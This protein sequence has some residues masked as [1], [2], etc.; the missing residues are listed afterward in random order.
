[1]FSRRTSSPSVNCLF[2]INNRKTNSLVNTCKCKHVNEPVNTTWS[3]PKKDGT[4]WEV[5]GIQRLVPKGNWPI[6][7]NGITL[8]KCNCQIT[9]IDGFAKMNN[10]LLLF[11]IFAKSSIVDVL[12]GF[13]WAFL[14]ISLLKNLRYFYA[15]LY[16]YFWQANP[17]WEKSFQNSKTYSKSLKDN[18]GESHHLLSRKAPS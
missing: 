17:I 16:C 11:T 14:L 8:H 7:H 10:G 6:W 13:E 3:V 12:Q 4:I 9:K 18:Q 15:L 5:A 2:I 1:M